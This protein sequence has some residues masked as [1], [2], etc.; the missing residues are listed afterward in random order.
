MIGVSRV[1]NSDI[2]TTAAATADVTVT[3]KLLCKSTQ[4][5]E[6]SMPKIIEGDLKQMKY[7]SCNTIHFKKV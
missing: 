7:K 1:G 5:P 6:I 4:E 3:C 2:Q